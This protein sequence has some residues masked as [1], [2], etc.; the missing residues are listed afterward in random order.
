MRRR[1]FITLAGGAAAAS[2]WSSASG[3]QQ[4]PV[5]G[6]LGSS[7]P[8]PTA[9]GPFVAALLHGLS[10]AGFIE[11]RNVVIESRWAH[12]NFDRLPAL[13]AELV[14]H[15]VAVI[16]TIGGDVVAIA[17]KRATAT[18]PVVF[19]SGG[20]PIQLGLVDSFNRPGGNVTGVSVVTSGSFAKRLELLREM[21]PGVAVLGLL[22][23]RTNPSAESLTNEIVAAARDLDQRI[24]FANA[25]AVSDFESALTDLAQR[26]AR[27]LL[28]Y[29]DVYFTGH[30]QQLVDAV[31]R[32]GLPAIY[33]FREF[34]VAGGLMSYGANFPDAFRIAGGYIGRILKGE[35]PADLPI[36]QPT[37]FQL[38][39]NLKTAKTLGLAVP[40][41]MLARADEVIE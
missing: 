23:N 38:V 15:P 1:E 25:S 4:M 22:V 27:A 11:G 18:V 17:A 13:V 30:R 3:A 39:I 26:G 28:V 14:R 32:N 24:V 20:D 37:T 34:A 16:A 29:P 36:Q 12:G 7:S 9:H 2:L 19:T 33:Q 10:S 6:V 8:D 35:K 5:V 21:V 40:P 31:A 41:T